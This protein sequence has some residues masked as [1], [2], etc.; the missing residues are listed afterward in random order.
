MAK[1]RENHRLPVTDLIDHQTE[2]NDADREGPETDTQDFSLLG[3]GQVELSLPIPNDLRAN[4]ESER[5]RDQGEETPP[6][7]KQFIFRVTVFA[8]TD[9]D[10][11]LHLH[12]ILDEDQDFTPV[13]EKQNAES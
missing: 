8:G 6:E 4:D 7:Q 5:C 2:Q 12:S 1:E 3:L 10:T 9:H 11:L 13:G